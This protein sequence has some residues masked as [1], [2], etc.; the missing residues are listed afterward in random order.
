[1]LAYFKRNYFYWPTEFPKTLDY[2]LREF[3]YSKFLCLKSLI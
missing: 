1:M 3:F 2:V